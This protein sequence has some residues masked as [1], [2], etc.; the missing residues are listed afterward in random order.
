MRKVSDLK[1][2]FVLQHGQSDCGVACLLSVI[3]YYGGEATLE[4][5]REQSGTSIQGTT[6]L[7][8]YQSAGKF[9][10]DAEGLE[11]EGVHNLAEV[12]E[13]V[14]LHVLID[15]R[16]QHYFVF[17]GFTK[18]GL[19]LI[20]DPA[21]GILEMTKEELEKVWQS[22]TLLKLAPNQN[23]VKRNEENAKKKASCF[24]LWDTLEF[25]GIL[26]L[27]LPSHLENYGFK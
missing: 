21:K 24:H 16:L 8:L 27:K 25:S 1:E 11:A 22:R 15:N 6:L 23:F 9:G 19:V 7:G 10:F 2:S 14:I 12:S 3:K 17:Y 13:P 4:K 20:G 18:N 5:L 26:L